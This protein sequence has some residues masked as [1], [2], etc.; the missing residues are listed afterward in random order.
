MAV[1]ATDQEY[2][3]ANSMFFLPT[4]KLKK[5]VIKLIAPK[6]ELAP[7]KCKEKIAKSTPS[8]GWV[9]LNDNGGQTVHPVPT[10]RSIKVEDNNNNKEGG[11]SQNLRLFK[12]GKAIS[13]APSIKGTNQL[14]NPPINMGMTIKK[15]IRK[16]CEVIN[17]LKIEEPKTLLGQ[18]NSKRIRIDI[19]KPTTPDQTP[20]RKYKFPISLWLVLMNHRCCP[21]NLKGLDILIKIV[22]CKFKNLHESLINQ[23]YI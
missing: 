23:F 5:V 1:I 2:K 13:G 4:H 10:P 20:N 12:R 6:I 19:L 9:D 16:A 14:A 18:D 8:L 7:A 15:I 21:N 22:N 11:K 3:L 17:Q